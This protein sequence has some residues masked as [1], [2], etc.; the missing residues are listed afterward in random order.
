M[1]PDAGRQMVQIKQAACLTS[2]L[3]FF[4]VLCEILIDVELRVS[5]FCNKNT[6]NIS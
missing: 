2:S 1:S 5:V 6:K 4:C 3:L